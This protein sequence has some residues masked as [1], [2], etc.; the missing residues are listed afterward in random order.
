[1]IRLQREPAAAGTIRIPG[2]K[3]VAVLLA[4]VGLLTTLLTIVL[5]VIPPDEEPNKPLAI[6]KVIGSTLFLVG[7]GVVV[8]YASERR[9][10][11]LNAPSPDEK[12]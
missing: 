7:A 3:P 2:G 11:R 12:P 8:Y 10:K 5:S 6:A 9:Q 4:S 1:M